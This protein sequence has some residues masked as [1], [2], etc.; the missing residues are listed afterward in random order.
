MTMMTL[1]NANVDDATDDEDDVTK[2]FLIM[3]IIGRSI[4]HETII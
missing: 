1:C 4:F 3:I 2:N